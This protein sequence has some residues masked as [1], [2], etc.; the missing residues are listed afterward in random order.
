MRNC[1]A[2]AEI[3][4][5]FKVYMRYTGQGWEIP[6]VLTQEQAMNP[7]AATFER[8]FEEDYTKLFGRTVTG[9]DIEI[10]VWSVNATTPPETVERVAQHDSGTTAV[11]DGK[12]SFF[13]PAV[14]EPVQCY[15]YDRANLAVGNF[16]EGPGVV[17]EDETTIIIPSSRNAIRQPDGCIDLTLKVE[18]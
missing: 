4:S 16:I 1:D 2:E 15:E 3:L 8:L 10:T 5:E 13:D 14:G 18:G 6:I 11:M 9:L 12:R 17:F 7:D